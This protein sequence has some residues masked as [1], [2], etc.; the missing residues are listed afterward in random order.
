MPSDGLRKSMLLPEIGL[1]PTDIYLA[2]GNQ[3][4][5]V[6]FQSQEYWIAE[7]IR[8]THREAV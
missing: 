1:D 5:D 3:E 6:L 4:D 2:P 7:A 8:C